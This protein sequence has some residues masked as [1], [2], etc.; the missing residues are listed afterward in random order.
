MLAVVKSLL[1]QQCEIFAQYKQVYNEELYM[2]PL[3]RDDK[4]LFSCIKIT[5]SSIPFLFR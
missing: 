1:L 3:S 5:C 4:K 2:S